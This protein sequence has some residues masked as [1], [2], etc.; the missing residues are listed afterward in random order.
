MHA[1]RHKFCEGRTHIGKEQDACVCATRGRPRDARV[2]DFH[3]NLPGAPS[4]YPPSAGIAGTHAPAPG[5]T[6]SVTGADAP[7]RSRGFAHGGRRHALHS[8]EQCGRLV[9]R[10][11]VSGPTRCRYR[12]TRPHVRVL[13]V[14]VKDFRPPVLDGLQIR[15]FVYGT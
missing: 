15:L 6:K 2:V 14:C 8:Q 12:R 1:S 7:S 5:E 4:R 11:P 10:R 13:R 3:G 9:R